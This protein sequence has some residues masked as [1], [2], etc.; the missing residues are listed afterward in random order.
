MAEQDGVSKIEIASGN[1]SMDDIKDKAKKLKTADNR[2][3]SAPSVSDDVKKGMQEATKPLVEAIEKLVPVAQADALADVVEAAVDLKDTLIKREP[4]EPKE[5]RKVKEEEQNLPSYKGRPLSQI[6]TDLEAAYQGNADPNS[7]QVVKL[8]QEKAQVVEAASRD[9][10]LQPLN[11]IRERIDGISV[12]D[13][14]NPAEVRRRWGEVKAEISGIN[15]SALER[16]GV[17]NV[18][19][20]KAIQKSVES[21]YRGLINLYEDTLS[22]EAQIYDERAQ[23]QDSRETQIKQFYLGVSELVPANLRDVGRMYVGL[24]NEQL[25]NLERQRRE[26]ELRILASKEN[27]SDAISALFGGKAEK[28][29]EKAKSNK[30]EEV[31]S[32]VTGR[33]LAT[34]NWLVGDE[35][36]SPLFLKFSGFMRGQ[37]WSFEECLHSYLTSNLD[38]LNKMIELRAQIDPSTPDDSFPQGADIEMAVKI[39]AIGG[40]PPI[41]DKYN[42]MLET[43]KFPEFNGTVLKPVL[44][45]NGLDPFLEN[46]NAEGFMLKLSQIKPHEGFKDEWDRVKMI[47][48]FMK[49]TKSTIANLPISVV[50]CMFGGGIGMALQVFNDISKEIALPQDKRIL[51]YDDVKIMLSALGIGKYVNSSGTRASLQTGSTSSWALYFAKQKFKN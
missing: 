43:D 19:S 2:E 41:V 15:S 34:L 48:T 36:T 21:A 16:A 8:L 50:D 39:L 31:L 20:E 3:P 47:D 40:I 51:S 18:S 17:V 38:I 13:P 26:D 12:A 27:N 42:Q 6:R 9:G 14:N 33:N 23:G 5:K 37:E 1:M 32:S 22:R 49:K 25:L 4:E 44:Q 7:E 45:R 10:F 24:N 46:G 28:D 29:P 35:K 30:F 11:D